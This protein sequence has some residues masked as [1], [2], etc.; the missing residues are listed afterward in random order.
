MSENVQPHDGTRNPVPGRLVLVW[1]GDGTTNFGPSN[2]FWAWEH[3]GR[4]DVDIVR[5]EVI[6]PERHRELERARAQALAVKRL[7]WPKP[8]RIGRDGN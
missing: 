5:Y 4:P 6:S 7:R 3:Q 8:Y 1:F 2:D